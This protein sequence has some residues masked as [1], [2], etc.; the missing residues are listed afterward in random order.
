MY[1]ENEIKKWQVLLQNLCFCNAIVSLMGKVEIPYDIKKW[2]LLLI[3]TINQTTAHHTRSF[4]YED[5][6]AVATQ[7]ANF[8]RIDH[9]T[10]Y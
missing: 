3:Y 4:A 2:G 5:D 8:Q 9:L 1:N 7:H 10:N 6:L